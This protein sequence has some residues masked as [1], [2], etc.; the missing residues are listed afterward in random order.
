MGK[1]RWTKTTVIGY[2]FDRP[3]DRII[4][5]GLSAAFRKREI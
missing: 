2:L 3:F 5:V 1:R 4:P